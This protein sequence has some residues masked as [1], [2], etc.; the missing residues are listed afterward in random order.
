MLRQLAALLFFIRIHAFWDTLH[1][2]LPH[3]QTFMNDG[4]NSVT[5]DAKLHS[6]WFSRKTSPWIW[7]II[8]GV[9]TH[10]DRPGRGTSQVEK[11][12]R[13]NWVTWFL[14]VVYDGARTPN[15]SVRM[16][17]IS[18]GALS[19]RNKRDYSSHLDVIEILPFSLCLKKRLAIRHINRPLVLTT[20]SIPS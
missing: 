12:P 7:A 19:C 9:F 17:W 6:N 18:L 4:P 3:V 14:T 5:W 13:L 15:V 11:S 10:S 16:A 1:G 8:S 20:L 2:D